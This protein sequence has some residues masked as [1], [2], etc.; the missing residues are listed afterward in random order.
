M[1]ADLTM[2]DC[3]RF[4]RCSANKCPLDPKWRKRI[5][6]NGERVCFYA[7]EAVK[8]GAAAR[9]KGR[10]D[11]GIYLRAVEM[12]SEPQNH[13]APIRHALDDAARSGST[14]DRPLPIRRSLN[15]GSRVMQRAATEARAHG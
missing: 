5:H 15:D 13:G 3:P 9:F 14:L 8:D 4:E 10:A 12:L 2:V 6:V 1:M 11:E 7:R